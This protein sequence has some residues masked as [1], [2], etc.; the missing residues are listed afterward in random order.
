MNKLLLHI[1]C[2]PC[3]LYPIKALRQNSIEP[4][5]YFYNPNIHPF[6]EFERRVKALQTVGQT[7]DFDII[8]DPSGYGLNRWLQ[9]LNGVTGYGKRCLICYKMRLEQTAYHA[10]ILGIDT[11]STTLLYSKY[12]FHEAIKEI[13][14]ECA[15]QYGVKFYY[16]DFRKGWVEGI[17]QSKTLDI[18][19]QPY[20]GCI[21]SEYDRYKKQAYKLKKKFSISYKQIKKEET[22]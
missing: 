18:Y 12:Q 21:F 17:K 16:E 1:C 15:E 7:L 3:S 14:K 19:R 9:G 22:T 5:G 20:C 8:W 4:I 10:T 11:I 2:G 6:K 13:G